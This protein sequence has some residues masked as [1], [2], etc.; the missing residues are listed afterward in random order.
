MTSIA[1]FELNKD[2]IFDD[3]KPDEVIVS[4]EYIGKFG[5]IIENDEKLPVEISSLV[6]GVPKK[7]QL[8]YLLRT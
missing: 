4:G 5:S 8:S 7:N 2:I 3:N 6:Y 1:L